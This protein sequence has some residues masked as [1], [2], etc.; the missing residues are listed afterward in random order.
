MA[1]KEPIPEN[2]KSYYRR[3][4]ELSVKEEL[5]MWGARVVVPLE[6]QTEILRLLH[7]GHPGIIRMKGLAISYYRWPSLDDDI[8]AIVRECA[9]CQSTRKQYNSSYES[10]PEAKCNWQRI[11][12]D[13]AG[14][15]IGKMFMIMVDAHSKW[16]EV[17]PMTI[18]TSSRTIDELDKVFTTHRSPEVLVSDNGTNFNSEEFATYMRSNQIKH[19]FTPPYHPSSNGLAERAVQTFKNAMRSSEGEGKI[20]KRI[21]KFLLRYRL[22]PHTSTGISPGV[23]LM[24]RTIRSGLDCLRPTKVLEVTE[25]STKFEPGETVFAVDFR[26]KG[27]WVE[28]VIEEISNSIAWIAWRKFSRK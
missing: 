4:A 12:I 27:T 22:T 10:W 2:L 11:N 7:E 1:E 25:R 21:N 28:G 14:P 20:Q 13:F 3:K 17:I 6:I 5:I 19:I 18:V 16:L 9:G 15:F 23:V 8:E 26:S 24:S